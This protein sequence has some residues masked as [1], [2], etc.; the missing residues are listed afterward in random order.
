MKIL[1]QHKDSSLFFQR[2]DTW[3]AS[4]RDAFDFKQA[5]KA[6]DFVQLY[7]LD[8]VRILVVS[9]NGSGRM[10]MLPFELPSPLTPGLTPASAPFPAPAV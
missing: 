4:S 5:R 7:D 1:L 3:T 2:L 6:I 8:N 9:V 10:H